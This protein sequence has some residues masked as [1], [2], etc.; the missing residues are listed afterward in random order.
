MS[1]FS[2]ALSTSVL[3]IVAVLPVLDADVLSPNA[4]R[5]NLIEFTAAVPVA[6]S[7]TVPE[8]TSAV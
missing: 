1:R 6:L 5:K 2:T 4:I 7:L 3:I 8:L